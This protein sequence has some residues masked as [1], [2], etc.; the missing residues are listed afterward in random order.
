[1]SDP[2]A[3]ARLESDA[4]NHV[5]SNATNA[6]YTTTAQAQTDTLGVIQNIAIYVLV[7]VNGTGLVLNVLVFIVLIQVS[8]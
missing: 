2:L 6:T 8:R 1:M 4:A 5:A 3:A 7:S